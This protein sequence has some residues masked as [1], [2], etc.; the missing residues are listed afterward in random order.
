MSDSEDA[1]E[2]DTARGPHLDQYPKLLIPASRTLRS[3]LGIDEEAFRRHTFHGAPRDFVF[4]TALDEV[5]KT[6]MVLMRLHEFLGD[7]PIKASTP[8]DSTERTA[9]GIVL[10]EERLRARRLCELLTELVLFGEKNEDVYYAHFLLLNELCG[11]SWFNADLREFH[12]AE[13]AWVKATIERATT[14]ILALEPSI[15]PG[16]AWYAAYKPPI[17]VSNWKRLRSTARQRLNRALPLMTDFERLAM[18]RTRRPLVSQ[19]HRSTTPRARARLRRLGRTA[20]RF[21]RPRRSECL[22]SVC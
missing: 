22:D 3:V 21:P 17:D 20:P 14:E 4:W 10:E 12:G 18:Q 8:P 6:A 2:T 1:P 9:I 19:V 11:A 15:D 5:E 16:C 7:E 13:S